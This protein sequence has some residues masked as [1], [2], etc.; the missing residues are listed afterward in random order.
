ME[1]TAAEEEAEKNQPLPLGSEN[2][3]S[4]AGE[5]SEG[6]RSTSPLRRGGANK[7]DASNMTRTGVRLERAGYRARPESACRQEKEEVRIGMRGGMSLN[8][9]GDAMLQGE[10]G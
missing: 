3:G 2:P 1:D 9:R 8:S 5:K 10:A 6:L 7:A 4:A